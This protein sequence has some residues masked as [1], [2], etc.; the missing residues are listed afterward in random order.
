MKTRANGIE[1]GYDVAGDGPWLVLNHSMGLDRTMWF[2]QVSVLAESHR[3]L[4]WDA[5][6]HGETSTTPG[7]YDFDVIARDLL[8]LLDTLS[9]ERAAI[10]GL[11]MGGCTA[12]NVAATHP[13]LVSAL[14]LCDTTAWYGPDAERTFRK[15][16][17]GVI[18]DGIESIRNAQASRWFSDSFRRENPELVASTMDK[19]MSTNLQGYI[20]T[21]EGLGHMDLRAKLGRVT[22]PTLVLVGRDDESTPPGMAEEIHRGVPDSKLVA[23]D[24]GRHL[25]PLE[26]PE[27]FSATVLDFLRE[28]G[29]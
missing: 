11:S 18:N 15:R 25:W 17:E 5:R 1:I 27:V 6:G 7:A 14:V 9:I 12:I 10:V 22:C 4:T 19:L 29:T 16:A 20:A 2:Q 23:I 21:M 3:V 13:G 28:A 8:G 26:R 24:H